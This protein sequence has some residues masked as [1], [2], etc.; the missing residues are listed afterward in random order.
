MLLATL[1]C[2]HVADSFYY[3]YHIRNIISV[4]ENVIYHIRR[5]L[6][7]DC[8]TSTKWPPYFARYY[9]L[10]ILLPN[11]LGHYFDTAFLLKPL[12]SIAAY[13]FIDVNN[14]VKLTILKLLAFILHFAFSKLI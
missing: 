9:Y 7:L 13:S 2:Q 8:L 5:C 11:I 3:I 14:E 6:K 10:H 4:T 1:Q 12:K